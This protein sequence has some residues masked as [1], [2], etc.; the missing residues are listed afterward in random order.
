MVSAKR[1]TAMSGAGACRGAA[2]MLGVAL[3]AP[4]SVFAQEQ[5][6]GADSNTLFTTDRRTIVTDQAMGAR[7][8]VAA[9]F[10]GDGMLDIVSASS[11]DNAVSWF[12]NLGGSPHPEFSIKKKITWSSL[13]SRI[14]TAADI[15]GDG[16]QDVVL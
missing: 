3:L 7:C 9:D 11:N 10:D 4:A 14:V 13:G 5:T 6:A 16:D 2:A 8:A 12:K 1:R 15:D